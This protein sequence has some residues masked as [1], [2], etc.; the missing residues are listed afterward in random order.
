MLLT[1]DAARSRPLRAECQGD[2]GHALKTETW[3]SLPPPAGAL[4]AGR[5]V[6][7]DHRKGDH[8]SEIEYRVT[9]KN[10]GLPDSLFNMR[11]LERSG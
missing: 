5:V 4:E 3:E 8:R 6:V 11:S 1:V 2:S 10:E 7:I 9:K